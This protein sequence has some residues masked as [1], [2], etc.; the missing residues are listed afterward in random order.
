MPTSVTIVLWFLSNTHLSSQVN[1]SVALGVSSQSLS[2]HLFWL[3]LQSTANLSQRL[4]DPDCSE[5][6]TVTSR[7]SVSV[8]AHSSWRSSDP[9]L[10]HQWS[11]VCPKKTT[12]TS[13]KAKSINGNEPSVTIF[14]WK[15]P[16]SPMCSM[17]WSTFA[18]SAGHIVSEIRCWVCSS[19]SSL[20]ISKKRRF[21]KETSRARVLLKVLSFSLFSLLV[22]FSWNWASLS[23]KTVCVCDILA[24]FT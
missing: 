19:S 4:K 22:I 17:S 1:N 20:R 21:F 23:C 18:I 6:G 16:K 8:Q 10:Q 12:P 3:L 14:F 13:T 11:G 7:T 2:S 15:G 9:G 24:L 5:R